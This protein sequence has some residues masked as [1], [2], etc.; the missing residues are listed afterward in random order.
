MHI[1]YLTHDLADPTTAKRVRM[2]VAGGASVHVAGFSR[3]TPPSDIAGC[4]VTDLGRTYNGR[5]LQRIFAVLRNVATV[6]QHAALF[7]AADVIIARNLETLGIAVRGRALSK[8]KPAIAYEVLDIHR[9]LLREDVIGKTLRALEACLAQRASLIITSS[10]AFI[11]EY[12][13]KRTTLKLPFLLLENK[14]FGVDSPA[15]LHP[16]PAGPPWRIGWFGAIRCRKSLDILSKVAREHTGLVEIIIRG[17]PAYDQ[18]DDFDAQV[19][20]AGIRF[21]GAYTPADLAPMYGETHFSWAIDMFEEGLNSAWLLPNRVYEGGLYGAVPIT[22]HGVETSRFTQARGI[23][24]VLSEPKGESLIAF[25]KNLT[26]E[27]YAAMAQAV[28]QIP[29]DT[30]R[31]NEAECRQLVARIAQLKPTDAP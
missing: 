23:G 6:K 18:F 14:L 13:E 8:H 2:L 27:A 19:K 3:T 20:E 16:L 24:H 22:A 28:A 15:A 7:A 17:R 21:G 11:R 25:L 26:P 30:W 4:S 9:L 12:F 1:L 5:F 10:P 29:H 31:V